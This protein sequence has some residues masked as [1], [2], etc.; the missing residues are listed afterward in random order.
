[1]SIDTAPILTI[2]ESTATIRLNRPSE[3][4]RIDPVDV[5]VLI[6]HLHETVESPHVRVLV[7]TGTGSKTFCSGYTIQAIQDR[8][9]T[10]FEAFL[11]AL[12]TLPLPTLCVL[13]GSAYGGA[14]DIALCCDFRIGLQGTTI[15]VPAARFGLHLYPGFIRRLVTRLGLS[16]TKKL[17]LT[18]QSLKAEEMLRIGFLSER[19]EPSQLNETVDAYV[20]A[21]LEC[22]SSVISSMKR[23]LN[24]TADGR[25]DVPAQRAAFEKSLSSEPLAH[26]IRL[27]FGS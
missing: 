11:D 19:V 2:R 3:H 5:E 13:N 10:K 14:I 8:L 17:L 7:L 26:R 16:V 24:E 6:S 22:E 9:S 23:F 15:G 25:V 20:H 12:E 27:Y 18:A 1:M 4:N 21:I